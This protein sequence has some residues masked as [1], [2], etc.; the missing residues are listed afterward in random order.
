MLGRVRGKT[1]TLC[2]ESQRIQTTVIFS[3]KFCKMRTECRGSLFQHKCNSRDLSVSLCQTVLLE[4]F[5]KQQ[6]QIFACLDVLILTSWSFQN[7]W[8]PPPPQPSLPLPL[9]F[10]LLSFLPFFIPFSFFKLL[11]FGVLVQDFIFIFGPKMLYERI[12][13]L[14]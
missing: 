8:L 5:I 10:P 12:K 6:N 11:K 9:H 1:D 14:I 4:D 2:L 13:I 3:Q 7:R